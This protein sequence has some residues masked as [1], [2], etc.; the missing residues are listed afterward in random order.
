[1]QSVPISTIA[2]SSNPIHG[3]VYLIQHYVIKCVSDLWH[4]GGFSDR[5]DISEIL[6]KVALNTINLSLSLI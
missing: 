1:M 5:H 3:E 2:V 4:I 6:L